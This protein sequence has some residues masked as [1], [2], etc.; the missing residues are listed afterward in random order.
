[1]NSPDYWLCQADA[2]LERMNL[3]LARAAE[4]EAK[5]NRSLSAVY[6]E[7]HEAIRAYER[8]C[9]QMAIKAANAN[10]DK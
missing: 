3:A 2:C 4:A 5:G 9:L 10:S 1:M 8:H 6:R 7:Q